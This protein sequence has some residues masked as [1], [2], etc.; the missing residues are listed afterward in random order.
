MDNLEPINKFST[1][2]G[3]GKNFFLSPRNLII[4]YTVFRIL[5]LMKSQLGLEAMLEYLKFYIQMV[6]RS[7]P[8]VCHAVSRG[9]SFLS[10]EK[11]YKEAIGRKND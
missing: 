1:G 5:Y 2:C 10:V 4:I 8:D 11:I 9:L 7:N 3:E 6:D